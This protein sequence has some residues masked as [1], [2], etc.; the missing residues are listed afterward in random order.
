[1]RL[2][3]ESPYVVFD[4]PDWH[5]E[6]GGNQLDQIVL[7][8]GE[9]NGLGMAVWIDEAN[10]GST[11]EATNTQFGMML[12]TAPLLFKIAEVSD[13]EYTSD[14]EAIFLIRGVDW[15]KGTKM[16]ALCRVR[17]VSGHGKA[18]WVKMISFGPEERL[19]ELSLGAYRI[20]QSLH[21]EP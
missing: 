16:V 15:R 5:L 11:V 18:Y 6:P 12:L 10:P 20:L 4:A 19:S 7:H 17:I 14:E 1:V 21:I 13:P 3:A 8:H 9:H 2:G